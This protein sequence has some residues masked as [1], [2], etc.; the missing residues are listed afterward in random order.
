MVLVD[1]PYG[2]L[3]SYKTLTTDEG[4]K[5]VLIRKRFQSPPYI[6]N[7]LLGYCQVWLIKT[8]KGQ[9]KNSGE[10][11]IWHL[12]STRMTTMANESVGS[13]QNLLVPS[14]FHSHVEI[15]SKLPTELNRAR[16]DYSLST[17]EEWVC[18][19]YTALQVRVSAAP[20]I[21]ALAN[22]GCLRQV[23]AD[24]HTHTCRRL[25]ADRDHEKG[26]KGL[27]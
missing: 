10:E 20:G 1:R 15:S 23:N 19:T 7:G 26:K 18:I 22:A 6:K 14:L 4:K 13:F 21:V 2:T 16:N 11:L 27:A 12:V 3:I 17:T 5:N 25:G 9:T 24:Q 8:Y